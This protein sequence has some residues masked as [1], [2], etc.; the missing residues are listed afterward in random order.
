MAKEAIVDVRE[1]ERE[2]SE[3]EE[4]NEEEEETDEHFNN[5]YFFD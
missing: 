2:E 1:R 5:L 3:R 4:G